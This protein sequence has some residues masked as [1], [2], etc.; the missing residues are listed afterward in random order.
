L[1][2]KTLACFKIIALFNKGL[3]LINTD[4]RLPFSNL[5]PNQLSENKISLLFAATNS[6]IFL[7]I[8]NTNFHGK[9]MDSLGIIKYVNV[10]NFKKKKVNYLS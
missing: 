7:S 3:Q 8:D 2:N 1:K 9:I 5:I 6:I 4:L 10:I